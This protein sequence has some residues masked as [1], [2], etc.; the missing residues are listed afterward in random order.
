MRLRSL[1]SLPCCGV[2]WEPKWN[3]LSLFYLHTTNL[4][5]FMDAIYFC[6]IIC[7]PLEYLIYVNFRL[8]YSNISTSQ[9]IKRLRSFQFNVFVSRRSR[10]NN[11]TVYDFFSLATY[12]DIYFS[13][14]W[15]IHEIKENWK[16][17]DSLKACEI[18][19]LVPRQHIQIDA[20]RKSW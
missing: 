12:C 14:R 10:W 18:W 17:F 20:N 16:F 6:G 8:D 1:A 9:D 15:K 11:K 7:E 13:I 2:C 19:Y 4:R 3:L 5:G